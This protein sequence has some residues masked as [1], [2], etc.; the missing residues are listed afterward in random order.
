MR[1]ATR[2][3]DVLLWPVESASGVL[4]PTRADGCHI[5]AEGER[6]GHHHRTTGIMFLTEDG[7]SVSSGDPMTH[8]E[9]GG[10][11]LDGDYQVIQQRRAG[12][13]AFDPQMGYD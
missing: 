5:V 11:P 2:Q 13:G 7:L 1:K 6:S 3:G 12:G 10:N 8:P 9:H 4:L